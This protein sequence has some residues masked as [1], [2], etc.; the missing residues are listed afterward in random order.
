MFSTDT[1]FSTI[2]S[3]ESIAIVAA[4]LI[5]P[6]WMAISKGFLWIAGFSLHS[7]L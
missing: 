1:L 3:K 6:A 5:N 2:R 7:R 4:R